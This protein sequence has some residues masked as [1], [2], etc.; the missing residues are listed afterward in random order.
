MIYTVNT[1][2]ENAADLGFGGYNSFNHFFPKKKKEFEK[3]VT[4]SSLRRWKVW[5]YQKWTDFFCSGKRHDDRLDTFKVFFTGN[6][7]SYNAI[8]EECHFCLRAAA[9]SLACNLRIAQEKHSLG[10]GSD[11][12][13]VA[14]MLNVGW[15]ND[16][17]QV[18]DDRCFLIWQNWSGRI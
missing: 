8:L 7:R 13:G 11:E 12:V 17:C 10:S 6:P 14:K 5:V 15:R 16:G 3:V 9:P 4:R 2:Q 1:P 18:T